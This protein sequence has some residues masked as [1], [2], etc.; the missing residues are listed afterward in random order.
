MTMKAFH[1]F[2]LRDLQT[3]KLRIEILADATTSDTIEFLS[4]WNQVGPL[5]AEFIRELA[6]CYAEQLLG[7]Q[8]RRT[9]W[10]AHPGLGKTTCLRFFLLNIIKQIRR[11]SL[12]DSI[13]RDILVC[14]NQVT[15]L[16]DHILFLR[17]KLGDDVPELGLY[18]TKQDTSEFKRRIPVLSVEQIMETP[19][20]FATQNLIRRRGEQLHREKSIKTLTSFGQVT[21][22]FYGV[23]LLCWDEEAIATKA[24]HV[25]IEALRRF[26]RRHEESGLKELDLF[27]S[28]LV[29]PVLAQIGKR[30]GELDSKGAFNIYI[31]K[32]EYWHKEDARQ[33][34]NS[35]KASREYGDNYL[36]PD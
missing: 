35:T 8:P 22:T 16:E 6:F 33:N 25:N 19:I 13:K 9:I 29:D 30:Q 18:H 21:Y 10:P 15:E 17:E 23:R 7:D 11:N 32:L 1:Q 3:M 31:P 26:R 2:D 36:R 20:L 4:N 27:V 34:L 12:P 5:H 24:S 28:Q 14:S